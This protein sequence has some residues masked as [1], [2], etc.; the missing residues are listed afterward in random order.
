MDQLKKEILKLKTDK[1]DFV[2]IGKVDNEEYYLNLGDDSVRGCS[3]MGLRPETKETLIARMREIEPEDIIGLSR[4]D[5]EMISNYFDYE[6]FADD[7]EKNWYDWHDVQAER[8]EDGE[9][10]FLGF[11]S[12]QDIFGYWE[13]NKIQ[14]YS[15]Y[16][17]YFEE[18]GL[19][20]RDF[21]YINKIIQERKNKDVLKMTDT[22][23]LREK[24]LFSNYFKN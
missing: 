9:T 19:N 6:K 11:G 10:L 3:F 14:N 24:E 4:K 2:F 7:M 5:F 1:D 8:Y 22:E 17:N 23:K 21:N 18:I 12:G 16:C 15:D 20:E 13:T